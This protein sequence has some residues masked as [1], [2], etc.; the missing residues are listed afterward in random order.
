[1]EEPIRIVKRSHRQIT[2]DLSLFGRGSA[3][4]ARR[5]HSSFPMYRPTPL[6]DLADTADVLGR[7]SLYV[8]TSRSASA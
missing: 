2:A 3:L 7:A 5:F 8:R 4:I 6:V 1:M